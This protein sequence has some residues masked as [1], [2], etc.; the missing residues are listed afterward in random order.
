MNVAD[1][2]QCVEGVKKV[3]EGHEGKIHF[4][5]NNADIGAPCKGK[6]GTGSQPS[7]SAEQILRR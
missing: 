2:E 3:A 4:L 6:F 1:K 7:Q 5:V